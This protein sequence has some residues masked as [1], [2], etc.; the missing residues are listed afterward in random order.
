[1]CEEKGVNNSLTESLHEN[2]NWHIPFSWDFTCYDITQWI[3]G[4]YIQPSSS[5]ET[6]DAWQRYV[7]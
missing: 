1:M 4:T 2:R 3:N 7:P 5:W 6:W